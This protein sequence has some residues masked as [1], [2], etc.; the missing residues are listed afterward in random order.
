[1]PFPPEAFSVIFSKSAFG[2]TAL[3]AETR[4]GAFRSLLKL[5]WVLFEAA[6][7][8]RASQSRPNWRS[9]VR[10][11]LATRARFQSGE[12]DT[13]TT[14]RWNSTFEAGGVGAY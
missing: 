6:Y 13:A 4:R 9:I 5:R 10:F 8:R 11:Q 12:K 3:A 7:P 1:M 14:G 2:R